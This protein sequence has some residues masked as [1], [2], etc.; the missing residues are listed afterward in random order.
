MKNKKTQ[1]NIL[2]RKNDFRFEVAN[3]VTEVRYHYK[4]TQAQLAKKMGTQQPS[5][6]RI[7]SG[8]TL[9]SLSFLEK[10]AESVGTYLIAPRFGFMEHCDV[11]ENREVNQYQKIRTEEKEILSTYALELNLS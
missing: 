6:A 5:I 8:S 2:D 11:S 3:L 1:K 4:L 9:P 7:E 10:L